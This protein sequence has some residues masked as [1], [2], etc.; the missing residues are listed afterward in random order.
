MILTSKAALADPSSICCF[1]LRALL[2]E[3]MTTHKVDSRK[4][5]FAL[6]PLALS[7][8]EVFGL[9]LQLLNLLH[10]VVD[11]RSILHVH[12]PTL[13]N[14]ALLGFGRID[15]ELLEEAISDLLLTLV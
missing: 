9:A 11:L 15:Q 1:V 6:A 13:L 5:E 4:L 8:V 3:S 14:L 10:L 12:P 2:T 7:V